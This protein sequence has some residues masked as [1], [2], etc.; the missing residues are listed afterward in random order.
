MSENVKSVP[1]ILASDFTGTELNLRRFSISEIKEN[2]KTIPLPK[3][4]AIQ[5]QK[6]S[7]P[8]KE[9]FPEFDRRRTTELMKTKRRVGSETDIYDE[10]RHGM[11]PENI[12]KILGDRKVRIPEV[13]QLQREVMRDTHVKLKH[14]D[15]DF[16]IVV[17]NGEIIDIHR[18]IDDEVLDSAAIKFD[19]SSVSS[20]DEE[21]KNVDEAENSRTNKIVFSF[22]Q[23]LTACFGAFAHG[24][25]DVSNAIGP[26]IAI[27]LI[28]TEGTVNQTGHTP[29]TIL[30]F[31]GIG[32][33]FGLLCWGR[34][35]IR[36]MGE[37]LTALTA[38]RGFCIDLASASTVLAAS[39]IGLPVSTTHCKVGA[40]VGVGVVRD[41]HAVSWRVFRNIV[42]AWFVTVPIAALLGGSTFSV[43]KIILVDREI[44]SDAH[45][46]Q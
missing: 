41:Y 29:T 25:N 27:F 19:T 1:E 21:L 46:L 5:S 22:L 18:K 23:I 31:G 28:W 34:R 9:S 15:S 3:Q 43:L 32:I 44:L 45:C 33:S 39:F 40:V 24:G 36:T 37:D 42:I 20:I 17:H 14:Q 26:L 8:R 35:V 2:G 13:M 30:L 4:E 10:N 11:T 7:L 6:N 12:M 16:E 38:S